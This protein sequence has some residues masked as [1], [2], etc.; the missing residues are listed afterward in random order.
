MNTKSLRWVAAA[1]TGTAVAA[2]A[3]PLLAVPA[4]ASARVAGASAR[5]ADQYVPLTPRRVADTRIEQGGIVTASG[6]QE[7][8]AGRLVANTLYYFDYDGNDIPQGVAAH[9][10]NVTAADPSVS[11]GN[12]RVAPLCD[13]DSS[14]PST[15]VPTSSLINYDSQEVRPMANMIVVP[16]QCEGLR[17]YSAHGRAAVVIDLDGYYVG[18]AAIT[19]IAP[20]RIADTRVS[21]GRVAADTPRSFQIAGA[22]GIPADARAVAVNVTAVQPQPGHGNLRIYPDGG[23]VP[24]VNNI[25][26]S[27][28]VD[29]AAFV[30]IRLPADGKIDVYSAGSSTD[31]VIDAFAYYPPSANL[32]AIQPIR[33]YDSRD[34]TPLQPGTV[35]N[36]HV[37]GIAGVPADAQAV[38]LSVTAI[39]PGVVRNFQGNLRVFPAGEPVPEA[40][41]LNYPCNVSNFAIVKLTGDRVVSLFSA[42]AS[43]DVSLDVYGYVPADDT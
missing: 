42:R 16:D 4:A 39:H 18:D 11:G 28:F 37:A 20:A 33:V 3:V 40:S 31:V 8:D 13:Q 7:P 15:A 21:G 5:A 14:T 12:L 17:L 22:A 9:V 36:V 2:L 1:A 35:V 43:V 27:P 6:G 10:F 23:A 32:V 29:T 41:T 26:Y 25:S 30:V 34:Y 24:V 38:L 19:G